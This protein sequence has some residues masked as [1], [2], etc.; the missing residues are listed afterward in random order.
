M[1]RAQELLFLTYGGGDYSFLISD[2]PER[3][4]VLSNYYGEEDLIDAYLESEGGDTL[5]LFL[6]RELKDADGP[7]ALETAMQYLNGALRDIT[8]LMNV[9]SQRL[10]T[11]DE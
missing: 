10:N 6:Y 2:G 5:V 9:L 4:R 7:E 1:N 8:A 11:P 3:N